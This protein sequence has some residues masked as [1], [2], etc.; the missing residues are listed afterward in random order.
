MITLGE[1]ELDALTEIFNI[2]V[3]VA[4]DAL[5]QLT[6]EHVPL[7]VPV[8]ELTSLENARQHYADRAHQLCA[9]SQTYDGAFRTDA[10]LMFP[11]E[12]S[13]ALV[14]MMAGNELAQAQLAEVMNDAMAELG[15]IV[16]NAVISALAN[17]LE[18]KL[19]GT[20]P[21]VEEMRTENLF[22]GTG[23][24]GS[25]VV[26][27]LMI[28][29]LLSPQQ[30]SGFLAFLMSAESVQRLKERLLSHVTGPSV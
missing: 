20:L 18:I 12:S 16:L 29:F 9:I 14:R 11:Q 22:A 17:T 30:V 27:V 28:D 19:E 10:I 7:S 15:N 8:V 1:L 5:F 23:S 25:D 6:G 2:G 4:A 24:E 26:L 13:P 3:G 21:V